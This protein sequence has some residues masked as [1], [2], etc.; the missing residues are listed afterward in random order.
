MNISQT[1]RNDELNDLHKIYIGFKRI[2]NEDFIANGET[3]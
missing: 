2:L 1:M 3:C